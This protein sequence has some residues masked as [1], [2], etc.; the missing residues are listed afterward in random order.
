MVPLPFSYNYNQCVPYTPSP[1]LDCGF[2]QAHPDVA[3]ICV[4]T[5]DELF[6]AVNAVPWQEEILFCPDFGQQVGAAGMLL[7]FDVYM[8]LPPVL[9]GGD[10]RSLTLSCYNHMDCPSLVRDLTIHPR[11]DEFC[12]F[13]W[14]PE[15][16]SLYIED[17]IQLLHRTKHVGGC[18]RSS[19][20]SKYD[21]RLISK[22]EAINGDHLVVFSSLEKEPPTNNNP[23]LPHFMESSRLRRRSVA[24]ADTAHQEQLLRIS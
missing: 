11:R 7:D 23:P 18:T 4:S 15:G 9:E 3:E 14:V 16:V 6:C 22:D 12:P 24:V 20:Q 8:E 13:F 19:S 10:T 2:F 5:F 1:L 17:A 21:H